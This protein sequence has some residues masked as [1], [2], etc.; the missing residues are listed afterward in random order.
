MET[1]KTISVSFIT[2]A[3]EILGDTESGL[4]GS[5]IIKFI[6]K[7]AVDF[8]VDIPYS[9]YPFPANVPNKRT[10]LMKNLLSFKSDQQFRILCELCD[11]PAFK[12]NSE[13]TNLRNKL[14]SRYAH[15]SRQKQIIHQFN[16]YK[17]RPVSNISNLINLIGNCEIMAIQDD[18]FDN[19]SLKNLVDMYNLDQKFCYKFK[20]LTTGRRSR[21]LT[22]SFI[23]NFE[24]ETKCRL[25]IKIQN[26]GQH[27]RLI[28]LKDS[29]CIS[30]DFSLNDFNK[31]G[32]VAT[33]E[34]GEKKFEMFSERYNIAT[35]FK[36]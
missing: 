35:N 30:P 15:Y 36:T 14:L 31:N 16:T 28:F 21:G 20:V 22:K 34:D 17:S 24:I 8:D 10:V 5:Q 23:Q 32:H 25:E 4:S 13:V 7:Y 12:N 3:S 19:K 18:Y 9:L 1:P 27:E 26:K 2:Y 29:R 11:L 6:N 33:L